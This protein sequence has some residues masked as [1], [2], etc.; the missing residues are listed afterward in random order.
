MESMESPPDQPRISGSY[1]TPLLISMLGIVSTALALVAYHLILVRY[2]HIRRA[3]R[4]FGGAT[5]HMAAGDRQLAN[6]VDEKVLKK[7]PIV[8]YSS[9]KD[10]FRVDQVECVVCL[11]ELEDGDLVRLLPVCK[12]AFHVSCIDKWFMARSSCPICRSPVVSPITLPALANEDGDDTVVI[13]DD[14]CSTCDGASNNI[15]TTSRAEQHGLLPH[16][17]SFISP[18]EVE[19]AVSGCG[20]YLSMDHS[21]VINLQKGSESAS[22]TSS[23]SSSSSCRDSH[24]RS[25]SYHVTSMRHMD[26]VSLML[27][28]SF[29]RWKM[30]PC[31]TNNEIQLPK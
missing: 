6:G 4:E 9:E 15:V 17:A 1:I 3:T 11:G 21:Y 25:D 8:A 12:H 29:S 19:Y 18:T 20:R 2:C 30:A 7:I 14:P 27:L 24:R 28:R 31:I 5:S 22:S 13:S 16:C 10:I 23:S 26:R